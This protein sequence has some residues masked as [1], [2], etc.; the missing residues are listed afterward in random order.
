MGGIVVPKKGKN[1]RGVRQR[2]WG[3]WAAEIRDPSVGA[4]RWLG[5]FDTAVEAARAYDAAARAIRGSNAR[6]NFPLPDN[7]DRQSP[8]PGLGMHT[9]PFLGMPPQDG[10]AAGGGC[11]IHG[12][13]QLP[14]LR[15]GD[16]GSPGLGISGMGSL[17]EVR[18]SRGDR[19]DCSGA[20]RRAAARFDKE[21]SLSDSESDSDIEFSD[22]YGS[23]DESLIPAEKLLLNSSELPTGAMP[24]SGAQSIPI[25][26][27]ALSSSVAMRTGVTPPE[28]W[29]VP[30]SPQQIAASPRSHSIHFGSMGRSVDM[31][32]M[33]K[34]IME[35]GNMSVG[36]FNIDDTASNAFLRRVGSCDTDFSAKD[37]PQK[38][39]PSG[40]MDDTF[41]YEPSASI[42]HWPRWSGLC[43]HATVCRGHG[44]RRGEQYDGSTGARNVGTSMGMN[45]G[46]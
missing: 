38:G 8:I 12:V 33:V 21:N 34:R 9:L 22:D 25:G 20:D 32:D 5:T 28:G 14:Q 29:K 23:D 10:A 6:C 15:K 1:Y 30:L 26:P 2:P 27:D 39:R 42:W 16:I 13:G 4:R 24:M 46:S 7:A 35:G 45:D 37:E 44:R 17:E 41:M 36:S 40:D 31:V 11:Q 3:K 19:Q 18:W 43:A